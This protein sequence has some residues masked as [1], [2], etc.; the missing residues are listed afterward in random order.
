MWTDG[1]HPE[2]E[3]LLAR[4]SGLVDAGLAADLDAHVE[5]CELCRLELNG[6]VTFR[7]LGDRLLQVGYR[8][9]SAREI[10]TRKN[11]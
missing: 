2:L 5:G 9:Q 10:T 4:A 8:C 11:T 3:Q 6:K 1:R 7:Q